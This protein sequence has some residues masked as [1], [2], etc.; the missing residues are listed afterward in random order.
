[1][2]AST[3][4]P[5]SIVLRDMMLMLL[6]GRRR[7]LAI[8]ALVMAA[9]LALALQMER[10]YEANSSMLVLFGSE[11]SFRP[12]AGQQMSSGAG[13]EYEQILRTEADILGNSALYRSVI[14]TMGIAQLYPKLMEPPGNFDRLVTEAKTYINRLLYTSIPGEN[15][16][17]AADVLTE[18]TVKFASNLAIAVDRRS[19]VI[20]V[21]F[22]HTDPKL[23]AEAL[24]LLEAK[25]FEMRGKLFD[26]IQAP[27]VGARRNVIGAQLAAADAELN[28]FKREHD[29]ASFPDRQKILLAQQGRLEDDLT[30]TDSTISGLQARV[31]ELDQQVKLA[32]GQ[33]GGKGAANAAAP[34][35]GVVDAYRRRQ[36]EA[37]T[38]YRGSP[39]VDS[40]R[41]EMLKSIAELGKMRSHQAFLLAQESDKAQADLRTNVAARDTIQRQLADTNAGLTSIQA[42]EGRLHELE[43]AR[44]VLEDNYRAVTKIL[45]ERRIVESV[46]SN[47]QPSVRVVEAPTI[48]TLPLPTRR[49]VLMAGALIAGLLGLLSVLA[50]SL[51]RG[52]YLR[53]EALELNTGLTVLTTVPHS[54]ALASPVVLVAR[55]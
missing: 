38:A 32:S 11:Y 40:A 6:Y 49:L 55:N 17:R 44:S 15:S 18:A 7:M 8:M 51:L 48:P 16:D 29:I 26:D 1:M 25:Y 52:V 2:S 20:R 54:K 37:E 53:P 39:A 24:T 10:R 43:R 42:Q 46:N 14:Q 41:T 47:R 5:A 4:I 45:D 23:A 33:T 13:V 35:Q 36:V 27:I 34:L 12:T 3:S 22:T 30:K 28:T 50:P 31:T 9:T 21:T 19:A